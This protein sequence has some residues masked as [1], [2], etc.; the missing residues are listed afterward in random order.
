MSILGKLKRIQE[1]YNMADLLINGVD[2]LPIY[3]VRMGDNFLDALGAP[4][5]MKDY[6]ENDA[7]AEHG[8]TVLVSSARLASRELS[9]EFTIQGDNPDDYQGKKKAFFD[10][11][12]AGALTI[13]IPANGSEIYKLIYLGTSPTYGQSLNRCFGRVVVKFEEPNPTDRG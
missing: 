9:L 13:S 5:P 12:Y 7:R 8:K 4:V 1:I 3:G 6:I 10:L 11:L 2:A